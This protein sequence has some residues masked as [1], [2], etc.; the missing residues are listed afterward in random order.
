MEPLNV[1]VLENLLVS[2]DNDQIQEFYLNPELT[3]KVKYIIERN[4]FW[5]KR[6]EYLLDGEFEYE[7]E[8]NWSK[9]YADLLPFVKEYNHDYEEMYRAITNVNVN[10]KGKGKDAKEIDE[11]LLLLID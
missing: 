8:K 1:D 7:A 11:N 3:D 5:W 2:L 9:L 6:V 4:E 10:E